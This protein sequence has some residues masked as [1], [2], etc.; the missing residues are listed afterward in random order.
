MIQVRGSFVLAAVLTAVTAV[1]L[2][3]SLTLHTTAAIVPLVVAVPTVLILIEQLVREV[4]RPEIA[5]G[6][7]LPRRER[8]TLGWMLGLLALIW[9]IGIVIALPLY[10][11]LYLRV[12]SRERWTVAITM[13]AVTWCV[14]FAGLGLL[15]GVQPPAGAVWN[16]LS[17][18]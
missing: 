18:S 9:A 11:L 4:R 13:A 14:L 1:L 8:V 7:S 15:L 3:A 2:I 6:A 12:Q 10:L 17:R 16:W 5:A